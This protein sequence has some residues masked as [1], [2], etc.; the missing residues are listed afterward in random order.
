[1]IG[2]AN[3]LSAPGHIQF[4]RRRFDACSR[5]SPGGKRPAQRPGIEVPVLSVQRRQTGFG[6]RRLL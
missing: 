3:R 4:G 6:H 2:Q 5:V 1:M